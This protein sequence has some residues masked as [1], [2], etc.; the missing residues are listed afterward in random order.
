MSDEVKIPKILEP[1]NETVTIRIPK[2][3][4]VDEPA[5]LMTPRYVDSNGN[6]AGSAGG[7]LGG[8]VG[9]DEHFLCASCGEEV[10]MKKR[11]AEG[12]RCGQCDGELRLMPRRKF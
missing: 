3:H 11:D 2:V 4:F 1:V 12:K 7:P 10:V 8:F 6:E 9:P 5:R